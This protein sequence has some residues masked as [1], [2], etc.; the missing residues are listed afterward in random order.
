MDV[1]VDSCM[2]IYVDNCD[3]S[4]ISTVASGFDYF[5]YSC[6]LKIGTAYFLAIQVLYWFNYL[7]TFKFAK[8]DNEVKDEIIV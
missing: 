3:D 5:I 7:T 1:Y 8:K 4:F 6:I 2:D